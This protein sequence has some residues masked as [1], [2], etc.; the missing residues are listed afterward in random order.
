VW[1]A[2][3]CASNGKPCSDGTR[4]STPRSNV[5]DTVSRKAALPWR[6]E[7]PSAVASGGVEERWKPLGGV[8][9]LPADDATDTLRALRM[10]FS[11]L[12]TAT[13]TSHDDIVSARCA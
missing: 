11:T 9:L 8:E 2:L 1:H 13:A 7:Q 5:L 6:G 10:N 12:R 3:G 4:C